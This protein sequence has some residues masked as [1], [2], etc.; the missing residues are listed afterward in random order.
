MTLHTS[1]VTDTLVIL[2]WTLPPLAT[3]PDGIP[4]HESKYFTVTGYSL[5][6]NMEPDTVVL[7]EGRDTTSHLYSHL[8]DSHTIFF[9]VTVVYSDS[10]I[11]DNLNRSTIL[12]V[13]I[14]SPVG[15]CIYRKSVYMY[16]VH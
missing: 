4:I 1:L 15:K 16:S 6:M 7:L 12:P 14:P 3:T 8:F 13:T 9:I 10:R 2:Q 11:N 5:S